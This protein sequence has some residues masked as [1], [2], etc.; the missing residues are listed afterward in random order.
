MPEPK[1]SKKQTSYTMTR[2]KLKD[3]D[4]KF[5]IWKMKDGK[6]VMKN[7]KKVKYEHAFII[8]AETYEKALQRFKKNFPKLKNRLIK[9]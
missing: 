8:H 1:Q 4:F 7:G 6:Y 2:K 9:K 5:K 3:K